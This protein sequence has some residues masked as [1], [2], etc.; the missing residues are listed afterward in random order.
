M[1]KKKNG[2]TTENPQ[3][4]KRFTMEDLRKQLEKEH[5]LRWHRMRYLGIRLRW[6]VKFPWEM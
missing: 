2:K 1:P 6:R 4:E 3:R 5:R